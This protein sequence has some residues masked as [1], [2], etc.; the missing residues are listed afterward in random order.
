MITDITIMSSLGNP[1]FFLIIF[2]MVSILSSPLYSGIAFKALLSGSMLFRHSNNTYSLIKN[3]TFRFILE[4][5]TKLK[6]FVMSEKNSRAWG[7]ICILKGTA[8]DFMW[9][10]I[11]KIVVLAKLAA[12][13]LLFWINSSLSNLGNTR[14]PSIRTI[15]VFC[16]INIS[17]ISLIVVE[18]CIECGVLAVC[19]QGKQQHLFSNTFC[20]ANWIISNWFMWFYFVRFKTYILDVVI[21]TS[22]GII[23]RLDHIVNRLIY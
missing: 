1:V 16:L 3:A 4:T 9:I 21:Q 10:G 23:T 2:S 7:R 5:S 22:T 15:R 20:C 8:P 14:T 6:C 18:R 12:G 13:L 11:V 19:P 17:E